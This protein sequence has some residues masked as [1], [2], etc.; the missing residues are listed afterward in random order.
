VRRAL[1]L[2]DLD[3]YE[4]SFPPDSYLREHNRKVSDYLAQ[5]RLEEWIK[6][7]LGHEDIFENVEPF[8]V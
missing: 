5:I 2:P 4:V 8:E 7:E 6:E 1:G 3:I